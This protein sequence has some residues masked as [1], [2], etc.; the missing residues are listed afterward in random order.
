M[1]YWATLKKSFPVTLSLCFIIFIWIFLFAVLGSKLFAE[2]K[3]GRIVDYV[4]NFSTFPKA[5]RFLFFLGL[6]ESWTE[7][8]DELAV[9]W[10]A[11]TIGPRTDCGPSG[12]LPFILIFIL[13]MNFFLLPMFSSVVITFYSE[14][15]TLSKSS[16]SFQDCEKFRDY[17]IKYSVGQMTLPV[18]QLRGLM[19]KLVSVRCKIS[20]VP[21]KEGKDHNGRPWKNNRGY[22]KFEEHVMAL[23]KREGEELVIHWK[24]LARLAVSHRFTPEAVTVVD[25]KLKELALDAI[26]GIGQRPAGDVDTPLTLDAQFRENVMEKSKG[27]AADLSA[28]IGNRMD[29]SVFELTL[30][31]I[32][33]SLP[34]SAGGPVNQKVKI[35]NPDE[36]S[37]FKVKKEPIKDGQTAA[38]R[39]TLDLKYDIEKKTTLMKVGHVIVFET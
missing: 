3:S 35:R 28:V 23:S 19:E 10:P 24:Q 22:S 33:Q 38:Q 26:K 2:V 30:I 39:E 12:T 36:Y 9:S 32:E 7:V 25:I 15:M 37:N 13:G 21:G 31:G 11:C 14:A 34:Q 29:P 16:V 1:N 18:T 4:N 8:I 20:V 27:G 5:C 17:F 6:G